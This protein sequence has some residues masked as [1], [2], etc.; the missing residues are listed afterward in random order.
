MF[1][2]YAQQ[3][4]RHTTPQAH[5]LEQERQGMWIHLYRIGRV[6][7][8]CE[9]IETAVSIREDNH[10]VCYPVGTACDWCGQRTEQVRPCLV[11]LPASQKEFVVSHSCFAAMEAVMAFNLLS[12]SANLEDQYRRAGM[13]PSYDP[14]KVYCELRRR[15]KDLT[16]Y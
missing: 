1:L 12:V 4:H 10:N 8:T 15:V 6:V 13:N 11:Q 9:V 16:G 2:E 14:E 7:A 3:P 5:A